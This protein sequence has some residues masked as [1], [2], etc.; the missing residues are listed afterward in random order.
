MTGKSIIITGAGSGIGR[1]TA[2]TF[3]AAGWRVGLI[4]RRE[5]ALR[6]TANGAPA[7]IVLP[8]DVVDPAEVDAAFDRAFAAWGRLDAIFNNAGTGLIPQTP[9]EVDPD[10]FRRVI[11]VNV[12]GV[13]NC[14]HSAFRIMRA[15]VPQGGRIIN[16]GSISAQ[17]P[18]YG[19]VAYTMSKH[20]VTGLTR[21]LSLDGRAFDIACG[22]I[23]IGNALTDM[24]EKMTRGV[25]QADGQL[26]IEPVMPAAEVARAVWHMATLPKGTNVQFMTVMATAMPYIGR[27]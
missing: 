23:D 15:Q 26:Q 9:D 12:L 5:D 10:E 11:S 17:V 1:V 27:G 25:P 16:N 20:A 3:L 4:G 21:S 6:E 19:S 7:A 2:R 13:F 14:A 22:Q 8:C 24:A 18:R